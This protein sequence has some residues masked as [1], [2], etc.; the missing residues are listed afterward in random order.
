MLNTE[1]DVTISL[2]FLS[3]FFS[4]GVAFFDFD[5]AASGLLLGVVSDVLG[6]AS[7]LGLRAGM[8]GV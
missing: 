5:K 1:A 3:F 8:V 7:D 4:C 2:L 6:G